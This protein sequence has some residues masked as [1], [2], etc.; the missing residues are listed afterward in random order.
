MLTSIDINNLK[1]LDHVVT[2]ST[3]PMIKSM[4][5]ALKNGRELQPITVAKI[6]DE[7]YILDGYA[8]VEAY[9][10]ANIN[11]I[12][13][14]VIELKSKEEA[15]LWHIRLNVRSS[16]NILKLYEALK[17]HEVLKHNSNALG[18]DETM[19]K[20]LKRLDKIKDRAYSRLAYYLDIL[21]DRFTRVP[22]IPYYVIVL[23]SE[24][25]DEEMQ[26]RAV[27]F[28]FI[29]IE[30]KEDVFSY[31]DYDRMLSFIKILKKNADEK[32][33]DI[34]I[35]RERRVKHYHSKPMNIFTCI[36]GKRY[37]ISIKRN[38]VNEIEEHDNLIVVKGSNDMHIHT[39]PN[40]VSEE[41]KLDAYKPRW[42][43]VEA[44]KIIEL[45]PYLKGKVAILAVE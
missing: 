24:L 38:E 23:I 36:C 27:D 39:V 4:H 6:K 12:K 19:L 31:Q 35:S 29:N 26:E 42:Y 3:V 44:Y 8:R 9:R 14:D 7:Y 1:R 20:I 10:L 18:L 21:R 17:H 11:S 41:L 5:E 45:L 37:T 40:E 13:A 33:N 16:L 28:A 22:P 32:Y 15:E 2:L 25:E 43:V 34:F 30:D